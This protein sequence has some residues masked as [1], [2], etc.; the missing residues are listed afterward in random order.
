MK[1][2]SRT[3]VILGLFISLSLF[4]SMTFAIKEHAH[5]H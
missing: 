5:G 1:N 3:F 4:S 2:M